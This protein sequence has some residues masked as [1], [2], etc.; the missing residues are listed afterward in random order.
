MERREF[1]GGVISIVGLLIL[2]VGSFFKIAF[3]VF[4]IYGLPIFIIGLVIILNKNEDKIE[5]INYK[6]VKKDVKK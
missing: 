2:L 6:G 3:F 5:Q 1:L 4:L